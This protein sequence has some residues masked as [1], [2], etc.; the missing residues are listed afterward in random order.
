M[1]KFKIPYGRQTITEKDI[2]GVLES[3]T[4]DF[5]TQGPKV[6]E[7]EK[8]FASFVGAKYA[9]ACSNGTA[10]LHLSALALEVDSKH[11]VISCPNTFVASTNA[12]LYCGGNVDFCDIDPETYTI[13]INQLKEKLKTNPSRYK[14]IVPIHF[15]G[16]P[17]NM[18]ELYK[19]AKQYNLWVI[20]DAC[21]APGAKFRKVDGEW[22]SIGACEFSDLTCFSFH[23]VKHIA[24][25]EGGMITTNS[26]V[27]Y[28]RL[29]TLRTHGISKDPNILLKNDGPWY[30]EM[31]MLGYN[32]RLT[33]LQASLG[34]TQ[35]GS[36]NENLDNRQKVAK[37][38]HDELSKLPLI[39]QPICDDIY[40][41]YHLFI[42]QTPLRKELNQYLHDNQIFSQVHYIPVHLQPYY[43]NL[44][45]RKGDFPVVEEYYSNC[46]SLPMY[47]SLSNDEQSYVISKIYD[48]FN[49]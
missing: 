36:I 25:G 37:R 13:D 23:P 11:T 30:Y 10:A 48:F 8:V 27:L 22:S 33:D 42:I 17:V 29:V 24:C 40:H 7:F 28:D 14:G 21:H 32:Y 45:F 3:L 38:Y 19:L 26:K 12:I 5:M 47:H 39:L 6:P 34:I 43:M 44:G 1:K 20:E 2:S 18:E 41:A 4:S 9:V 16:Y 35:M 49:E 15:A 46:L 31:S